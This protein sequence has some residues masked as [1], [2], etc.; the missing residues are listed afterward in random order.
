ME[1]FYWIIQ[2]SSGLVTGAG[3]GTK[4]A[5]VVI[6]EQLSETVVEQSHGWDYVDY[7]RLYAPLPSGVHKVAVDGLRD[8]TAIPCGISLDDITIMECR[9]FGQINRLYY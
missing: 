9:R 2:E 8:T 7:R 4:V 3:S 6:D 5:I 1:L